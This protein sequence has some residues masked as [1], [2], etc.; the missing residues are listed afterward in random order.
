VAYS[1]NIVLSTDHLEHVVRHFLRHGAFSFDV[2]TVDPH[3]NI[4]PY[5]TVTWI[6]LAT[7][8]MAVTIPM[9]HERGDRIIGQKKEPRLTKTGKIQNRTVHIWSKAPEQL[10]PSQV[11]EALDPLFSSD[12]LK[13]AHNA[14]FDLGSIA[15]YR[16]G[17]PPAEPYYDTQIT[18]ALVDE[19]QLKSLKAQVNRI[20]GVDYDKEEIGRTG[21]DRFPFSQ[22][23]RYSYL[24]SLFTWLLYLRLDPLIDKLGIR[25]L[26]DLEM[27]NIPGI[28]DMV[29]HGAPVDA[30]VLR[31]FGDELRKRK[32][33]IQAE[34]YKR[35]GKVFNLG[36]SRQKAEVLYLPKSKGGQGLK[37]MMLTDGGIKKKKTGQKLDIYDYS[38]KAD[39]LEPY[40]KNPVVEKI[41]EYQ[42]VEKLISTY[43]DGILGVEGNP[44]KPCILINGRVHG[45]FNPVGART[46]RF[47]SSNPN[48]QNIPSR[49]ED[50][51]RIRSAYCAD[52]G[53]VLVVF[54]YSQIELVLLAH[55]IGK[56]A[57]FDGFWDGVD[58]HTMTA[59][60]V[61]G[62]PVETVAK[63]MRS[64][65]KGLNFA[66]VYGAGPAT[67]A[68]MAGISVDEAKT[69]MATHRKMFPEIYRYRNYVISTARRQKPPHVRTL[70]GRYRRL[71]ELLSSND[72]V[73]ARAER[74]AFN[75]HIQG[76]GGDLMKL[77]MVRLRKR[78]PKGATMILTVHDEIVVHAPKD[79]SEEVAEAVREAATGEEI[80]KLFRVPVTGELAIVERWSDAK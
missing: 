31:E 30:S 51:R 8:G 40:A 76:S 37:P 73:R 27:A 55:F 7:Y 36:S 34:V 32:V 49:T 56:G 18:C 57:L 68:D 1:R 65:A 10:R 43:V 6:S 72:E 14:V 80:Q 13:I 66:I 45:S 52:P 50:G 12:R 44:D 29:M 78:L 22:V 71:P 77:A 64:V 63:E 24:D 47:S 39:A 16:G 67:V 25:D 17:K 4:P 20:W 28:L 75:A 23:A 58:P 46:G 70:L 42:A 2:E 11:F 15:K 26:C 69:H 3:R 9:G 74:Q 41:L 60:L 19:N 62:V 35:A 54:D 59:S 48:L 33:D 38:T 21:V 53:Y 79:I 61:F 5:N